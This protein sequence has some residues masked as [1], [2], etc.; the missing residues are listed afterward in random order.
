MS[1]R[2]KELVDGQIDI[3]AKLVS[4]VFAF[5]VASST[6]LD[7]VCRNPSILTHQNDLS[8]ITPSSLISVTGVMTTHSDHGG[9]VVGGF[10]NNTI[11][12]SSSG[13][14]PGYRLSKDKIREILINSGYKVKLQENGEY[15]LNSYVY[16]GVINTVK[17]TLDLMGIK[18]D[19]I[20]ID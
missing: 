11:A 4:T 16:D 17:H 6:P 1:E 20:T 12:P 9:T 2:D 8:A 10:F 3:A 19:Q 13:I 18:Y 15:D 7:A 5:D 14:L